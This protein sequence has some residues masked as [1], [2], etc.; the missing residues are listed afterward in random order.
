MRILLLIPTHSYRVSDFLKSAHAAGVDVTVASEQP[1]SL[2][3]FSKGGTLAV[4]FKYLDIGVHQITEYA[5]LYPIDAI[6]GVDEITTQLAAHASKA[7]GLKGN[8]PDSVAKSANKYLFRRAIAQS[9]LQSPQFKLITADQ[10]AE[11]GAKGLPYPCVLKPVSL[12]ASRGVIRADNE[13]EAVN[14]IPRIRAIMKTPGADGE[15]ARE[16][17]IIAETFIPGAEFALEGILKDGK[18]TG[19]ALFDKPEPLD[20]P[21]FEETIYVTPSS[22]NA[23][24]QSDILRAVQSAANA[25]GLQEGPIHAEIRLNPDGGHGANEGPWLIELSPRSIGGL[26]A[27]TLSFGA[28]LSLEDVVIRHALG[29]EFEFDRNAEASGVMMIPIPNKGILKAVTGLE[30]ARQVPN[31]T[32]VTIS[33]P[34]GGEVI[35]LPEGFRYLGFIFARAPTAEN[36]KAALQSAHAYLEFEIN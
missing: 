17:D 6:I 26:C 2:E 14:A 7:L 19:L 31:I 16:M 9:G 35:P 15:I 32:E 30:S 11:D 33:I 36:V 8:P 1:Q 22:L 28:G 13:I 18:L 4:D 34:L 12:S 10:S 25:L 5:A 21:Y 29:Q 23:A 27:R 3:I 20:G 24:R